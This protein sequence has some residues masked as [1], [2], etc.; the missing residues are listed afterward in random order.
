MA[1]ARSRGGE[2]LDAVEGD[3]VE[4]GRAVVETRTQAQK[5]T[6]AMNAAT[7]RHKNGARVRSAIERAAR[8]P[9]ARVA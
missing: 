1:R 5:Q 3:C 6:R 8:T 4:L 9:P 2:V 7:D